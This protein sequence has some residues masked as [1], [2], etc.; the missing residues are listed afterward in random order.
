[1][2]ED[3]GWTIHRV[4]S[5]DWFKD[6]EGQIERLIRLVAE[7][8]ERVRCAEEKGW[9]VDPELWDEPE[10]ASTKRPT[11]P[12][13]NVS[14]GAG[15]RGDVG[16]TGFV[17][18]PTDGGN[19]Y[20]RPSAAPYRTAS[21]AGLNGP[22]VLSAALDQVVQAVVVVV[23][24]E[25]PIHLVDLVARVA[26]MWGNRAGT[27]I[28]GRI[29]EGCRIAE[30]HGHIVRRGDFVWAP[31]GHVTARS[32]IGLRMPAERIC[33][34][35]YREA[36]LMILR[37]GYALGRPELTNEVR[38]LLGFNRTGAVLEEAIG[39]AIGGLVAEGVVGE[40]SAGLVL[41]R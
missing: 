22:D 35:E 18:Q 34:E 28:A 31:S 30:R 36:V 4:W 12:A 3:R 11:V 25:A 40:G 15:S 33:P 20:V 37:T 5:T 13:G 14:T 8:K 7:S 24:A 17:R 29:I 39:N 32:R 41:K 19:G 27:R 10:E 38:A 9:S 26:S 1:V 23:K 6:R 2:L 16:P 21:V